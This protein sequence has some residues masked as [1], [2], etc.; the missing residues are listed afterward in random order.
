[1][2]DRSNLAY[3]SFYG[4]PCHPPPLFTL[5]DTMTLKTFFINIIRRQDWKFKRQRK[6]GRSA[7]A[8]CVHKARQSEAAS[9]SEALCAVWQCVSLLKPFLL[10]AVHL[11]FSSF[12]CL[13]SLFHHFAFRSHVHSP[14]KFYLP[15]HYSYSD[16]K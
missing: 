3:R 2:A 5:M 9:K 13:L 10:L 15:V 6:E 1:M 4:V 12:I 8:W 14:C 16:V 11:A 7:A